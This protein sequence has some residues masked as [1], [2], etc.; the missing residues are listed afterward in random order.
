[1]LIIDFAHK[2]KYIHDIAYFVNI[3]IDI[4]YKFLKGFDD[5]YFFKT[6]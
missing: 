2:L 4:S 5:E 3:I 6:F 1:M